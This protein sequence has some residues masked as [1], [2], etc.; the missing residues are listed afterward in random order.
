MRVTDTP[1]QVLYLNV[2]APLVERLCSLLL[3]GV[4]LCPCGGR[5]G[6]PLLRSGIPGWEPATATGLHSVKATRIG[7]RGRE[8]PILGNGG[9]AEEV[10]PA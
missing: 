4:V 1:G 10:L 9:V 7:H 3:R 5:G 6:L 2:R 8:R